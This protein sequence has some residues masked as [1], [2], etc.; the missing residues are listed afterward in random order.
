MIQNLSTA[1]ERVI[2]DAGE[3]VK[4]HSY[5]ALNAFQI[6]TLLYFFK[7]IARLRPEVNPFNL[8]FGIA[9]ELGLRV[10]D[11]AIA[12]G[13]TP[14]LPK[15]LE[16]FHDHLRTEFAR[17]DLP[18]VGFDGSL[19]D[20]YEMGKRM[21]THWVSQIPKG[22]VPVLDLPRNFTIP[23][24]DDQG[25]ALPRALT[26]KVDR[27]VRIGEK[28]GLVDWKTAGRKW[29]RVKLDSDQQSTVYLLGG[30]QIIGRR[31]DFFYMDIHLKTK[32]TDVQREPIVRTEKESRRLVKKMS[33]L[34]KTIRSGG[35]IPND[36]CFACKGCQFRTACS[37]WQ[38]S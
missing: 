29:D 28:L 1:I 13:V 38:D 30:S 2:E 23:L 19:D 27:W 16:P 14:S 15:A 31:P 5:S 9:Y 36:G 22:E 6:C 34:D 3:G 4:H 35:F 33:E 17:K 18:V 37:K 24:F 8:I 25:L 10:I 11:E 32:K 26:G 12:K 20:A 21:Y 7:Y